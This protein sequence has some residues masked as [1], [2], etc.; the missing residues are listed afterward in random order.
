MNGE[1]PATNIA[2]VALAALAEADTVEGRASRMSLRQLGTRLRVLGDA[3]LDEVENDWAGLDTSAVTRALAYAAS[4][5]RVPAG[6]PLRGAA[7]SGR[8]SA[9]VKRHLGGLPAHENAEPSALRSA[10]LA[11]AVWAG[12]DAASRIKTIGVRDLKVQRAL[13]LA[14]QWGV[15]SQP[16]LAN[17]FVTELFADVDPEAAAA[18]AAGPGLSG[19]ERLRDTADTQGDIGLDQVRVT[20]VKSHLDSPCLEVVETIRL[21]AL[22]MHALFELAIAS[23][24][25][26]DLDA[27]A[28]LAKSTEPEVRNEP[29][30]PGALD[31]QLFGIWAVTGDRTAAQAASQRVYKAL[32]TALEVDAR[33]R[34]YRL[35]LLGAARLGL[36]RWTETFEQLVG[37]RKLLKDPSERTHLVFEAASSIEALPQSDRSA[38]M[39]LISEQT[40]RWPLGGAR[41]LVASALAESCLS[42]PERNASLFTAEAKRSLKAQVEAPWLARTLRSMALADPVETLAM[43]HTLAK[44]DERIIGYMMVAEAASGLRG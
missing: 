2:G 3:A 26:L 42:V 39:T 28:T 5:L 11:L 31:A 35:V 32:A 34:L 43:A 30:W 23:P 22:R 37:D 19:P 25:G 40:A 36:T 8:M 9:A 38:A 18:L 21:P 14:V 33:V 17:A 4:A 44:P 6:R 15:P 10:E 7:P 24:I 27:V 16:T 12:D 41:A 20:I 1:T 29:L 13:E